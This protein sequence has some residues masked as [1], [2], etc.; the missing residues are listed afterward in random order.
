MVR[1]NLEYASSVWNPQYKEDI[2]TAKKVQRRA[3]KRYKI[4]SFVSYG[5]RLRKLKL[6]PL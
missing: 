6:S 5:D 4:I 1:S 3:T 2:E